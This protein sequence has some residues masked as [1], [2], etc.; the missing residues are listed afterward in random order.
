M[1]VLNAER[2][3]ELEVIQRRLHDV[4][5]QL[6]ET[7]PTGTVRLEGLDERYSRIL[8]RPFGPVGQFER[9][10]ARVTLVVEHVID[11]ELV[12][13]AQI[14]S[15]NLAKIWFDEATSTVHVTGHIPVELRLRVER[16]V[17]R[18]EVTDETVAS[19][20]TWGL[21]HRS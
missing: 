2:R 19:G 9:R 3:D 17:V 7:I 13:E 15:L 5:L 18:A 8:V 16:L 21:R 20:R 10:H 1:E 12:D 6:S 11:S 14:G 4:W